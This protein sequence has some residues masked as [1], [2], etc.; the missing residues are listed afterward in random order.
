LSVSKK[1]ESEEKMEYKDL[2]EKYQ[3]TIEENKKLKEENRILKSR[4]AELEC[5]NGKR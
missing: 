2:F 3:L 5:N 4:L 1:Q